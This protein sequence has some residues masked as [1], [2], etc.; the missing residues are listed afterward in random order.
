MDHCHRVCSHIRECANA[1]LNH[2][3]IRSLCRFLANDVEAIVDRVQNLAYVAD[4]A[5]EEVVE[6]RT[7]DKAVPSRFGILCTDHAHCGDDIV[8]CACVSARN[9][10]VRNLVKLRDP[11]P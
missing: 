8:G 1:L 6:I 10:L 4:S 11:E 5:G 7:Q 3:L 2:E 9:E